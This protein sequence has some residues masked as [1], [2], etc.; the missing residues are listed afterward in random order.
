MYIDGERAWDISFGCKL[1]QDVL[2]GC[3][4]GGRED[5]EDKHFPLKATEQ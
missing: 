3:K 1:G 2:Q 5:T 4:H